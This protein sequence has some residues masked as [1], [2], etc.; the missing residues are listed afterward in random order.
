MTY[1]LKLLFDDFPIKLLLYKR[2]ILLPFNYPHNSFLHSLFLFSTWNHY[3]FALTLLFSKIFRL[4][5][6]KIY[7]LI[8]LIIFLFLVVLFL[9]LNFG[10]FL[11]IQCYSHWVFVFILWKLVKLF[12]QW[13]FSIIL[14]WLQ[15][16]EYMLAF[17]P[18]IIRK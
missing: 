8:F 18:L 5:W 9:Y 13:F 14:N 7:F 16:Q 6:V 11:L 12:F 4:S 1:F 2:F 15:V 3:F 17:L 10:F